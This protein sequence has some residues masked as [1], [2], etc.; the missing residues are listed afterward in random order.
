MNDL[1]ANDLFALEPIE[2]AF[3]KLLRP[4][5]GSELVDRA[6]SISLDVNESDAN[7]IV[8]AEIPGVKK[9]D[10]DVRIDGNQITISAEVKKTSEEKD[11]ERLLRS[12]RQYGYASRS[13][14]LA[15]DVDEAKSNA[16]Y[17]DGI[18]ELTLPKKTTTSSKR[19]PIA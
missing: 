17:Q 6:P 19:L 2:D 7:Y 18:L 4:W 5:R 1:I 16:K 14:T 13:F 10:V 9:E 15:C 3:R 8:K 11:G 12:E